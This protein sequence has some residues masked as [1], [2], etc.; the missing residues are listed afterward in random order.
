M[1]GLLTIMVLEFEYLCLW[2]WIKCIIINIIIVELNDDI[3]SEGGCVLD[4]WVNDSGVGICVI[5]CYKDKWNVYLCIES[6]QNWTIIC[7]GSISK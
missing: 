3:R 7:F 2:R 5:M 1:S 4:D 6:L